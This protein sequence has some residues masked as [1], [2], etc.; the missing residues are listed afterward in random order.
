M[1][2]KH[3]SPASSIVPKSLQSIPLSTTADATS[4]DSTPASDMQSTDSS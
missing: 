3:M 1:K 4:T 2:K